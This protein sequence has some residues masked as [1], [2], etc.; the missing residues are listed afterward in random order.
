METQQIAVSALLATSALAM[1]YSG[2][3]LLSD[4]SVSSRSAFSENVSVVFVV[5]ST[6]CTYTACN[7]K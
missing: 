2:Y 1:I 5:S 3:K 6:V 7:L 4:V